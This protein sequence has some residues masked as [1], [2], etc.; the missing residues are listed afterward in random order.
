MRPVA[1]AVVLLAGC[2]QFYGLTETTSRDGAVDATNFCFGDDFEDGVI[3][4]AKW[5]VIYPGTTPL[6]VIETGGELTMPIDAG[7]NFYNGVVSVPFDMTD[8]VLVVRMTPALLGGFTDTEANLDASALA[9]YLTTIG[10]NHMNMKGVINNNAEV[11]LQLPYGTDL[12]FVRY[13]HVSA[14]MVIHFE[15]SPEAIDWTLRRTSPVPYRVTAAQLTLLAG[16]FQT[17]PEASVA[18]Y[19]SVQLE[20]AT[21]VVR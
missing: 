9:H 20:A 13:R 3:D 15:T 14:D 11:N 7:V 10:N 21:C 16:G 2:N 5:T 18:R 4:T 1:T 8:A 12:G 19:A 17:P 6:P